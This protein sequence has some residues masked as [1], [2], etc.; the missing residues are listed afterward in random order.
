MTEEIRAKLFTEF[1][2]ADN[3][4]ARRFGGCHG[5]G[6]AISRRFAGLMGG[7]IAVESSP[8]AG[9]AFTLRAPFPV[10]LS[11][12]VAVEDI[13]RPDNLPGPGP[14]DDRAAL[15]RQRGAARFPAAPSCSP[16]TIRPTA[17]SPRPFWRAPAPASSRPSTRSKPWPLRLVKSST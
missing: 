9:S 4:I 8:G 3:S 10:I 17:P 2:Q 11:R 14:A 7:D 15:S 6:L 1:W 12:A 5:L 16:R 13:S